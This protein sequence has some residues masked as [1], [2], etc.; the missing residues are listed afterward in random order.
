MLLQ[1]QQAS[2]DKIDKLM[3]YAK[4]NNIDLSVIDDMEG[5]YFLPGKPLSKQAITNIITKGR[6]SGT[7]SM[8]EVHASIRKTHH[9]D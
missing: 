4:Q 9:A 8:D 2:S 3:A 6:A 7:I 1:L 5:N